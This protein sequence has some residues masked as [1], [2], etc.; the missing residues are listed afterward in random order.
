V[1]LEK[2]LARKNLVVDH[3]EVRA[4][5]RI[6]KVPTESEA[7]RIAVRDRLALEDAQAAFR[8]IRSRGGLDDV[9]HRSTPDRRHPAK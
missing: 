2:A 7:V 6:L 9:F 8:R 5:K 4:L 3:D 1:R